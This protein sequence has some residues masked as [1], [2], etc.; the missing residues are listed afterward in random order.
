MIALT[1]QAAS[2]LSEYLLRSSLSVSWSVKKNYGQSGVLGR[3][4][5]ST[6]RLGSC[7]LEIRA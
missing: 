2:V 7:L 3:W 6:I 1:S 5:S 4:K